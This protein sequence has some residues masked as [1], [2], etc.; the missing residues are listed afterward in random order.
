MLKEVASVPTFST[1]WE[2]IVDLLCDLQAVGVICV[3]APV[4]EDDE[5]LL[6]ELEESLAQ[7]CIDLH[8][9]HDVYVYIT[10]MC[11]LLQALWEQYVQTESPSDL[12]DVRSTLA[13]VIEHLRIIRPYLPTELFIRFLS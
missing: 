4:D 11:S 9:E 3:I 13:M 5:Y 2:D 7:R 1:H 10:G 6:E 8:N 12:A